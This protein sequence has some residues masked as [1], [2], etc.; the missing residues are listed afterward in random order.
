MAL[1]DTIKL[2]RLLEATLEVDSPEELTKNGFF[3]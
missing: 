2:E 3:K 1:T